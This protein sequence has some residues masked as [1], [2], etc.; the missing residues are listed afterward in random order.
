MNT[1]ELLR[2]KK[3]RKTEQRPTAQIKLDLCK[4]QN[5]NWKESISARRENNRNQYVNLIPNFCSNKK[6]RIKNNKNIYSFSQKN[7]PGINYIKVDD[8]RKHS[9]EVN[10]RKKLKFMK[11]FSMIAS[12]ENSTNIANNILN[13]SSNFGIKNLLEN[14]IIKTIK[15]MKNQIEKNNKMF[16]N[17]NTIIPS[18]LKIKKSSTPCLIFFSTKKKKN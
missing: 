3:R 1:L 8:S 12:N 17:T 14:N 18:K 10:K 13:N 15:D 5:H 6:N 11:R 9:F 7:I 4:L 16:E 2:T